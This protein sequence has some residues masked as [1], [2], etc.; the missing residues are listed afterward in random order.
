MATA[1]LPLWLLD[2]GSSIYQLRSNPGT[3]AINC[4]CLMVCNAAECGMLGGSGALSMDAQSQPSWGT[5]VVCPDALRNKWA[6]KLPHCV[7]PY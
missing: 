4:S 5:A 1:T 3:L 6:L 7:I 2:V